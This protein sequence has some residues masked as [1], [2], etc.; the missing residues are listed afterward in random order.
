M[1]EFANKIWNYMF[2]NLFCI[3]TKTFYDFAIA[4]MIGEFEKYLPSPE[5]IKMDFPNPCGWCTGMEDGCIIGGVMLESAIEAYKYSGDKNYLNKIT[6]IFEGLKLC[7]D[8]SN[9][10]GFLA[11][12]VS[13]SDCK[14][15]Y[16]NSSRD[17]Y[18]HWISAC[19]KYY[20]SGLCSEKDKNFIK[21]KLL[22]FA[23]RAE[24]NVKEETN[25][26]LLD[27]KGRKGLVTG[28]WG[29]IM[30]HE[31]MRLPMIYIAAWKVGGDEHYKDLYFKYRD[32]ALKRSEEI[33][34][35]K[36]EK[37]SLFLIMNCLIKTNR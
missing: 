12:N 21:E 13:P 15:H 14:T 37:Y 35:S 2:N 9:D 24:N 31:Y 25:W 11:R 19:C 10:T 18:T 6:N 1:R 36:L 32:I 33:D 8:V 16:S 30:P 5:V 23:K 28:M 27:E 17:Q 22:N 20:E 7:A 3:K 34:F 4:G 26:N 29:N